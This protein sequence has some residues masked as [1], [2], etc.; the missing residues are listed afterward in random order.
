MYSVHT[1]QGEDFNVN[2]AI[3]S[4]SRSAAGTSSGSKQGLQTPDLSRTSTVADMRARIAS[5]QASMQSS[6][7]Q[8]SVAEGQDEFDDN[9]VVDKKE[10]VETN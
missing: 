10:V 8:D 1:H 2:Q 7:H 5:R 4:Y 3:S 9:V 6:T